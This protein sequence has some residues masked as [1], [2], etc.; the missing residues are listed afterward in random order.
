MSGC[1]GHGRP[2]PPRASS[3]SLIRQGCIIHQTASSWRERHSSLSTFQIRSRGRGDQSDASV[4]SP[5]P[6]TLLQRHPPLFRCDLT[7]L[8]LA[9]RAHRRLTCTSN[10]RVLPPAPAFTPVRYAAT[11]IDLW[12]SEREA[13]GR[14]AGCL[15][16]SPA[17]VRPSVGQPARPSV[18][19]SISGTHEG[20]DLSAPTVVT[21]LSSLRL[22]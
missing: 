20:S 18:H 2:S 3:A 14:P 13:E 17:I 15:S 4:F 16:P 12:M 10:C 7:S 9:R 19:I 1:V 21:L 5:G 8:A 22:I 11:G 6:E